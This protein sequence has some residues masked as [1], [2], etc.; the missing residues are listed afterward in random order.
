MRITGRIGFPVSFAFRLEEGGNWSPVF[1]D[2][3]MITGNTRSQNQQANYHPNG[4]IYVRE[5]NDLA[6]TGLQTL[7]QG[8]QPYLM[9]RSASVD[10]DKDIDFK[11]A[12]IL[13][14]V[15]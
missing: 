15:I 8:A 4:A 14:K 7:Y 9:E 11:M 12:E 13:L 1:D 5:I 3:P 10:I 2:S 6:Q